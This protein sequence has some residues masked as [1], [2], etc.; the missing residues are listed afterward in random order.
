VKRA[1]ASWEARPYELADATP[2]DLVLRLCVDQE[3]AERR[4]PGHGNHYL[5]TR[6][7]VVQQL[8][9][10]GATFGVV[11]V[12]ANQPYPA[13]LAA[14][15]NA[16]A[17]SAPM[18]DQHPWPPVLVEFCGPPAAGKS[19][20][21]EQ[22]ALELRRRGRPTTL[23]LTPVGP[24]VPSWRRV[25][26]KLARASRAILLRP[27][28]SA[29]AL[30]AVARSGQASRRDL[31]HRSLN[32]L[33]VQ[34][35]VHTARRRPGV[36]V[37]DQGIVQ[38]V[39]SVALRG[40][41]CRLLDVVDPGGRRLGPDHLVVVDVPLAVAE[42]RLDH[43]PGRQSRVERPGGDPR[44][45]LERSV[46]LLDELLAEWTVR[47][48]DRVPTVVQRVCNGDGPPEPLVRALADAV[49]GASS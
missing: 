25:P 40:R 3:T 32:W 21:A 11:E 9:F 19:L 26:R 27:L 38:E 39:C 10:P 15:R 28:A 20:L 4:R 31:F 12:D 22:L 16:I 2:P 13:V 41:G 29:S 30:R 17:A 18:S 23:V 46:R 7:R 14:A 5:R 1:L 24:R 8:N 44:V 48:G 37:F 6:R 47:F 34:D 43:R 49:T 35:A 45:E 33:V 42:Q 36:H